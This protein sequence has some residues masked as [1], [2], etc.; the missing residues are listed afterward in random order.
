MAAYR[1]W[2]FKQ[3]PHAHFNF[4]ICWRGNVKWFIQYKIGE[5]RLYYKFYNTFDAIGEKASEQCDDVLLLYSYVSV[6]APVY[7]HFAIDIPVIVN[8]FPNMNC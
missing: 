2:G 1:Q 4:S 5:R 7:T 6:V 3:L 8:L